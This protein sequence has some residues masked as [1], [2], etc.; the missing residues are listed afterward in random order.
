MKTGVQNSGPRSSAEPAGG[1]V[2]PAPRE[3][4]RLDPLS[5]EERSERMRRI[6]SS[7]TK[8][9]LVVRKLVR[10]LG[11]RYRLGGLGLPGKPDLVFKSRKKVIFVHG[12]FWHQHGCGHYKQPKTRLD[13]WLPKLRANVERDRRVQARLRSLG[14]DVLVVWECETR[15]DLKELKNKIRRFLEGGDD[16]R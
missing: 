5:P 12:C 11:F 3:A 14:W 2:Q 10:E 6:K 9:E 4:G 15:G 1:S 13:F 8:P 7:G 16:D